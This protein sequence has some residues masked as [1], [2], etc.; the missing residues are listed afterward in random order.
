MPK[1]CETWALTKDKQISDM[2]KD[3]ETDFSVGSK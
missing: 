1:S 3:V 2:R